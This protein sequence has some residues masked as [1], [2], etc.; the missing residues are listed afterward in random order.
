MYL[1]KHHSDY[2]FTDAQDHPLSYFKFRK[3]L[4]NLL[5]GSEWEG[6]SLRSARKFYWE[7][8]IWVEHMSKLPTG[9]ILTT[10]I[11]VCPVG[12]DIQSVYLHDLTAP[13]R[14]SRMITGITP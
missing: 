10:S 14:F 13:S 8:K 3:C 1:D 2:L 9:P 6:I 5:V 4:N 12:G 7:N 11:Y